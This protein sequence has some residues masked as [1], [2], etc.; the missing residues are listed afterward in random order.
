MRQRRWLELL[1]DYNSTIE[2]HSGKANVVADSWS[3]KT[4]SNIAHLQVHSLSRLFHLRAMIVEL[5]IKED[6]VVLATI[7]VRLVL[8]NNEKG[9]T[10]PGSITKGGN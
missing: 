7:K 1:K 10:K 4:S 3:R 5:Y 2:Y 6:G 9:S 8:S